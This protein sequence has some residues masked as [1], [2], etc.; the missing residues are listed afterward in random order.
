MKKA[1]CFAIL[2]PALALALL[3]LPQSNDDSLDSLKV[4]TATQ[5]LI[6]ENEFVRVI[7][8]QIPAGVTEPLHRHRHGVVIYL[9]TSTYETATRDGKEALTQHNEG[10]ALW[11]EA[12]VHT[13]KNA[14]NTLAHAIRIELKY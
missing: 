7:D 5:K 4:C 2:T 3:A 10:T 8:D 11:S 1:F 9:T 13:V 14:G 6:F 12:T